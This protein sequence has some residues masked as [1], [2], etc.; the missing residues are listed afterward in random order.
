MRPIRKTFFQD[1]GVTSRGLFAEWLTDET[2][3]LIFFS[4]G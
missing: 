1:E 4:G 2:H 3:K